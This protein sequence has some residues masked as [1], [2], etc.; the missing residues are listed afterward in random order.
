LRNLLR[1]KNFKTKITAV[2]ELDEMR[3]NPDNYKWGIFYF[4]PKDSRFIVPR[5][6]N[7]ASSM[8]RSV[9]I[10]LL[11][12]SSC[13][14]F[15]LEDPKRI[16]VSK[17]IELIRLSENAYVHVSVST[18]PPYG[19]VSSN[20]LIFINKDEAFLF[21]TP[22]TDI[23]TRTLVTWISNKMGL[24][25]VGFVPNHWHNDCMGGLGY[26]Q[27]QK[28]KSYANQM[29]IDIAKLKNL[30]VPDFGFSDSL[31]LQLGDKSIECFYLGVA[32]STDNI[33]VWIP[34]EQII[35]A[36]CMIKSLASNNLGNIAI[37][38]LNAYP[39]TI[40]KVA[41][42]FPMAKYVIPGHGQFGGMDLVNHTKDLI[43]KRQ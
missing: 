25:I 3:K 18:I 2:N 19:K 4:N 1:N 16:K 33:V 5:A 31:K 8:R 9:L 43:N 27:S 21:D 30:P 20:G 39:L 41:D 32:H 14:V 26:L 22:V 35:F 37:G 38:D 11:I 34:S 24:R 36:G 29:T 6:H 12:L 28:V 23:L 15:S 17:D 40:D 7:Q 10:I 13:N 42:K